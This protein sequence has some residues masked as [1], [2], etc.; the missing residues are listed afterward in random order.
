MDKAFISFRLLPPIW[1]NDLVFEELVRT[2]EKHKGIT[3][4]VTLFTSETHPPIPIETLEERMRL[5]KA[6][7]CCLRDFGYRSGINV[8]ATIGHHEENLPNSLSGDYVHLT[9]IHG[10]VC[11]GAICPNDDK[12]REFIR[13]TYETVVSADPD[14]IWIDD[15]IRLFGHMPLLDTCFCDNCLDIFGREFGTKHTRESLNKALHDGQIRDKLDVRSAWLQHNRNTITRLFEL[16]ETTVHGVKP[17]LVLGSMS[18]DQFYEGHDFNSRARA[19]SGPGNAPVMW[20]PGGGFYTEDCL[21]DLVGKSHDIGRQVASLPETVVSIQ[22]EIENNPYQ[23]LKKSAHTT[24]L[25]AASHIASGCTG[26]AFNILNFDKVEVDSDPFEEYSSL[27][28]SIHKS[29]PFYDLLVSVLRRH[30]PV[31]V[32]CGWGE[33]SYS[34]TTL[35]RGNWLD[36]NVPGICAH[37]LEIGELGIPTAYAPSSALVTLLAGDNVMALSE[38]EIEMIM[39]SGAYIDA[40]ALMRLNQMGYGELTG[41]D[42]GDTFMDDCI[43]ELAVHPING[44]HNG[45]RRDCRQSFKWWHRPALALI[46]NNAN[47]QVLSGLVDYNRSPVAPCVAGIFENRLGGKVCVAGYYPWTYLQSLP[48]CTQ[49]K[50]L[51]RWLSKDRLPCYVDSYNRMNLWARRVSEDVTAVALI[52]STIEPANNTKLMLR[53]E[54]DDV[55]VYG[56]NCGE[57]RITSSWTDGVYKLFVLPS[58]SGWDMRLILTVGKAG[59]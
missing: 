19:L 52:N 53:T 29:R 54:S 9:D 30:P 27:L 59:R 44:R 55:L 15:D 46:P 32:F 51:M 43:E 20:R 42:V 40:E 56:M 21:R 8:L 22:S 35:E 16:I 26:A 48:K 2:F 23:A 38:R 7:M 10:N 1:M 13:R 18:S 49:M 17:G 58:I 50:N 3:D 12:S 34:T 28:A 45:S 39:S 37:M 57:T 4:E 11:L 41:F 36:W 14:Y 33:N 5:A 24:T 31:G 25:E 6:R 47:A